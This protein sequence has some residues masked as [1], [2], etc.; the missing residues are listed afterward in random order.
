MS[1]RLS[2][3]VV[4]IGAALVGCSQTAALAPVGGDRLAMVR[5]AANDVLVHERINI[6]TAPICSA[7]GGAVTCHGTTLA[8]E[9]ITVTSRADD[10]ADMDVTVGT[11]TL[12]H[13]S[14]QAELNVNARPA[15]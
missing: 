15:S 10:Q 14:V 11:R 9:P 12:Y 4:V 8:D 2:L 6:L 13:G 1:V 7:S 5:F 3:L